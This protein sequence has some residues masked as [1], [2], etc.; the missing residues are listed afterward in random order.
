[1]P[2]VFALSIPLAIV[3]V[4]AAKLLWIAILVCFALYRWRFG[5]I[6]DAH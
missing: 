4:T 1:V 2:V 5:S 6:R 3:S